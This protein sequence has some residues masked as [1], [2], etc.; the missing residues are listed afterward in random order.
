MNQRFDFA[1]SPAYRLPARAFGIN[2]DTAW[3]QV[4]GGYLTARFGPWRLRTSVD[5]V[6]STD[7]TGDYWWLKTVGPPHLS[8]RDRGVSMA[9]NRDRGLCVRF[10]LPVRALDPTG[11][12]RHPGAT[13]TVAD[14]EGLAAA[15]ADEQDRSD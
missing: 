2:P 13:F 4:A 3:V 9:T 10:E 5:N 1:F 8:L 7:V 6:V 11:T 12:I 14:P 15:I